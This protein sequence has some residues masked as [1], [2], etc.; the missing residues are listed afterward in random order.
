VGGLVRFGVD[1]KDS[2]RDKLAGLMKNA[3]DDFIILE[4]GAQPSMAEGLGMSIAGLML[5]GGMGLYA[6]RNKEDS[7]PEL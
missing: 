2:D 5:L 6:C 3:S 7:A 4:E 1:L